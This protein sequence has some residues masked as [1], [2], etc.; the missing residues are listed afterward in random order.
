L[1]LALGGGVFLRMDRFELLGLAVNPTFLSGVFWVNILVLVYRLIAI[2]D[3]YRVAQFMNAHTGTGGGRLGPARLPGSPL[4]IAGVIAVILVMASSHVVVARYDMLAQQ[5]T[6]GCIFVSDTSTCEATA[7]DSPDPS[8]AES[9]SAGPT[10]TPSAV[11]SVAGTP[12]PEVPIPAWNGKDR[13][14]ILLIGADTQG[15]GHRTDTMIT[16]SID[17]VT[18]QVAMFSL[19]RDTKNVPMPPEARRVWGSVFGQKINAF[20][21]Q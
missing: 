1:A 2:V 5:L 20:Y 13:L 21:S 18:K 15:H 7:S 8:D 6:G 14:N 12:V 17:P 11:P 16:V 19:P 10:E 3:A 9:V 4:A